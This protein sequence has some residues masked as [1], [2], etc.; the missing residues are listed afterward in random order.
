M[1]YEKP[2]DW[3]LSGIGRNDPYSGWDTLSPTELDYDAREEDEWPSEHDCDSA[4][5]YTNVN[6][7]SLWFVPLLLGKPNA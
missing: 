1:K 7:S 6:R 4:L 3:C 5:A 2:C